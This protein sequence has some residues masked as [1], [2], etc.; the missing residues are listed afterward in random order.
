M[1]MNN[2]FI[3]FLNLNLICQTHTNNLNIYTVKIFQSSKYIADECTY[4]KIYSM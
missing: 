2:G 3:I 1:F 4:K